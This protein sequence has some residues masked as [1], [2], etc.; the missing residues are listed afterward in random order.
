MAWRWETQNAIVRVPPRLSSC[1]RALAAR[2]SHG[3]ARGEGV[4]VEPGVPPRDVRVVHLVRD[5]EVLEAAE[6]LPLQALEPVALPFAPRRI[7]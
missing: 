3:E 1:S 6:L 2:A 7:E 5:A 4:L